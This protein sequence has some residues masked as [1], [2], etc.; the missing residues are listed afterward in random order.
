VDAKPGGGGK[1]VLRIIFLL[2]I[3]A[4]LCAGVYYGAAYMAQEPP[5]RVYPTL[6]TGGTST[7]D[8]IMENRWRTIYRDDHGILVKY[9]S[10]GST[11]GIDGMID[12]KFAIAFTHAPISE[13]KRKAAQAKGGEIVQ[14]PVVLCAVV[15]LYNVK[16]LNDQAPLNFTGAV[17]ADIFLGKIDSWDHPDLQKLNKGVKLPKKKIIVVHREDS[18]GTTHI[19]TD[20]LHGSSP[21]WAKEMGPAA[22]KIQWP[23]GVGMKRNSGVKIHVWQT[24]GAIGYVDLVH[25]L[26]AEVPY[27][28]VQNKDGTAFI[29]ADAPN[30]TAAIEPILTKIPDDLT[31]T[32]TNQPGE[33]AY[34]ICGAVWAVCFQKQAAA[35]QKL[36]REF[37]DWVIHSG[38]EYAAPTFYA[39][40]PE[41]LVKRAAEQVKQIKA[42]P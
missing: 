42:V 2:L 3:G 6:Q 14:I 25:A 36:V 8:I 37:L 12:K 15:P 1:L 29:H 18:S 33:K 20:F 34:P 21:V 28:A 38:Q 10:T 17:L 39:P 9:E 30:M 13:E 5:P 35:D 26:S 24:D 31:F 22:S 11:K 4:G 40:M 7:V 27:G 19:F 41:E 23:V 16:E 32:L